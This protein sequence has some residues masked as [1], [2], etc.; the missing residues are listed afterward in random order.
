MSR[1]TARLRQMLLPELRRAWT[2]D[3]D[4]PLKALQHEVERLQRELATL[5][6]A[7]D[8]LAL[9]EF[10]ASRGVYLESLDALLALEPIQAH[11]EQAISNAV[12]ESEPTTHAV[13]E[14]ILPPAFYELVAAAIPPPELF[15]SRDPVKQD[16]HLDLHLDGAPELTR[17]VWQYFD[18]TVVSGVLVPALLA[19]FRDAVVAH[20]AES[21]DETFGQRAAT[22]S[23]HGFSG[24][25]HLRRPG[26]VLKPHLDPKRVVIT[27]LFY[28]PRPGDTEDYGTQ[29]HRVLRPFKSSVGGK[30]YPGDHDLPMELAKTV[31]YRPNSLLAFVNSRAAHSATLPKDASLLERYAYQFYVKPLD[32]DLKALLRELPAADRAQWVGEAAGL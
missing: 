5:R 4:P 17:R 13:I 1:V 7:H 32:A 16:F 26:Y 9:R 10:T 18:Q 29:L 23:H 22:M 31:P 8:A 20:Y 21:G 3:L 6:S 12:V 14:N 2:R 27:G 28:F 24:R 30:F 11:I 25:L 19:R 15:P